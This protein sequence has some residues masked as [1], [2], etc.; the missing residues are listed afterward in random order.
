MVFIRHRKFISLPPHQAQYVCG[1]TR[2]SVLWLVTFN[3]RQTVVRVVSGYSSPLNYSEHQG[4]Y[5]GVA[6]GLA[7]GGEGGL[8][9]QIS[10]SSIFSKQGCFSVQC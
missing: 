7:G 4:F 10:Y 3:Q 5:R 9:N 1:G 2:G 6:G 8:T